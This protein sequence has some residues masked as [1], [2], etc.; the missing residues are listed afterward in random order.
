MTKNQ[1]QKAAFTYCEQDAL[2]RAYRAY[3]RDDHDHNQMQ[4]NKYSS[5]AM[6]H[7]DKVYVVLSN[8]YLLSVYRVYPSGT[9]RGVGVESLPREVIEAFADTPE[10]YL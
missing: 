2:A 5:G 8:G 7:D 10:N 3:F 6:A 4:P 9:I 1:I